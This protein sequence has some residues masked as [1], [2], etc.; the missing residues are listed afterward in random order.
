MFD[1]DEAKRLRQEGL[2][3]REIAGRLGVSYM[4]AYYAIN[5]EAR[6]RMHER[7]YAYAK[8]RGFPYHR[9]L[10]A[11]GNVK[12]RRAE[13]CQACYLATCDRGPDTEGRLECHTCHE[14]KPV[15]LFPRTSAKKNLA[16][17]GRHTQCRQ[18]DTARKRAW[19]E[20]QKTT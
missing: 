13:R 14:W 15:D 4:G 10:C 12:L 5:D 16:R 3:Y 6:A 11:C 17:G 9:D 20:G 2:S 1:H 19:R 18:C 7:S 8:E